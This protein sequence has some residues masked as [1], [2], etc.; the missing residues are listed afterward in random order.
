MKY[1]HPYPARMASTLAAAQLRRFE[2][3]SSVLDPMMGSG[4]FIVEAAS[5]GF[6]V[7]GFDI[8]PLAVTIAN[9]AV[10]KWDSSELLDAASRVLERARDLSPIAPVDDETAK[11]IAYWF[12]DR[13]AQQLGSLAASIA[14]ELPDTA[15]PLWCALSRLI[16][17]KDVGVSRARDVSHGRPHRI[18]EEASYLPFER[19]LR[20]MNEIVRR[21]PAKPRQTEVTLRRADARSMELASGTMD[22]IVTSPP[23]LTAI[24]YMRA[25]RMSLV[26]MGY[27]IAYLRELRGV[28]IGSERSGNGDITAVLPYSLQ[29]R[30]TPR[31]RAVISRYSADM[32]A[33]L[34]E[35]LRVL[36][37]GGTLTL[38]LG[39]ATVDGVR[40]PIPSLVDRLATN[41]G[42]TRIR[43]HQRRL[44]ATRRYLPPPE[45][46]GSALSKRLKYE[47]VA[48]YRA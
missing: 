32:T 12:D 5:R 19:Y 45:H 34:E 11:F 48:G 8:D 4:T 44:P 23:Y 42:F 6:P 35:A 22:H 14:H 13:A 47:V 10:G 41:V 24:D 27:S 25:H 3:G 31:A 36:R 15:D 18:R 1:V 38:V 43:R 26:W 16:I 28:S 40:I 33:V 30:L 39:T 37:T 2:P 21:R 7:A 29:L 9:T 46:P 17:T 20:S